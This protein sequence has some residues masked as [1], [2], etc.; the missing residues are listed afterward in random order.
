MARV[1][2]VLAI[3]LLVLACAAFLW[4][5]RS[6]AAREDLTALYTLAVGAF[7]LRAS[8]ELLRGRGA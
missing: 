6:L 1:V 7:S 3:L 8:T 5:M 4:G 2:D